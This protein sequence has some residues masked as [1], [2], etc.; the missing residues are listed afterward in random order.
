MKILLSNKF[1][2]PRGGDCI[3]TINLEQ[4]LQQHGH[5]TAMFAM[6]YSENLPSRW[7]KYFPSEVK[8]SPGLGMFEAFMRPLGTAEV[9]KKFNALLDDFQ[10]DVVHLNNIHTQLSPVIAQIAH[11]R[12]I[13]VVWTLH[14]YKL[15]CPRYDCLRNGQEICEL[16]FTD[17]KQVLKNRCMKNSLFASVLAY[18]EA[19]KW[20]RE[21]LEKYTDVFICPSQF[22]AEKMI[23]GGFDMK[24]IVPLCNFIDVEKTKKED[25]NQKE[26]YYCFVG[27]LSHTKGVKTLIDAAKT[28]PYK[29]KIIGGGEL[30][31]E[32][33][34]QAPDN[35]EFVGYKQWDGIKEI[36]GNA[37]FTVIP[38]EWYENNPLSVIEAESL[39]T[40]VLGARIGGIPELIE[41]GKT[42]MLF[43]SRNAADLKDKIEQ[44]F[45][46]TFDYKT[47]AE[48]S[49]NRY[50]AE[51]YYQEIV[52]IY[53]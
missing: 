18:Q 45:A 8:F 9:K 44:M 15:L 38:S 31:E 12:G 29:L 26:D 46:T 16:C 50:S 32:L 47:I 24:K 4:L 10:P 20:T 22:M 14:D 52:K 53:R 35:I 43:E 21:K 5:E 51:T 2:Y 40:P 6:Q 36:V 3:Y 33:M 1:Y 7:S 13:R 30:Q 34:Q 28:L 11:E 23:Q 37:R 25:Y 17:K 48:E 49:Q 19:I 27:R 41:T 39:G 42:G